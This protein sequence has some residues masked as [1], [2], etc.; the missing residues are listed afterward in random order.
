MGRIVV[1]SGSTRRGGNTELLVKAFAEGAGRN[2]TVEIVSV[3]DY[4]V[5]PCIGCNE[6][7]LCAGIVHKIELDFL[8]SGLQAGT[9]TSDSR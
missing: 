6:G 2:H 4:Q 7:C 5:N 1:L 3:V 9:V 8:V